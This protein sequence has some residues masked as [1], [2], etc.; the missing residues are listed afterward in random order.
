MTAASSNLPTL[1]DFAKFISANFWDRIHFAHGSKGRLR[2]SE[3]SLTE[4]LVYQFYLMARAKTLPVKIFQSNH[5]KT[6]GSDLEILLELNGLVIKLPCQ[7]K[8][9]YATRRYQALFHKVGTNQQIDL[10]IR[11]AN[12]IGGYPI[13][14]FYNYDGLVP[15]KLLKI[16]NG[17][18]Q[19]WGCSIGSAN[20]IKNKFFSGSSKTPPMFH[21]MHPGPGWPFYKLFEILNT[22]GANNVST[23]LNGFDLNVLKKYSIDEIMN[24]QAF[25]DLTS[26][27]ALGYVSHYDKVPFEIDDRSLMTDQGY[28]NPRYRVLFT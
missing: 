6:N 22:N 14:M 16:T 2:V 21:D 24:D 27:E 11:Y 9:V 17:V 5:E 19:F 25:T 15:K 26:P 10:L 23:V 18:K 20:E 13:Y 3:T 8:I 12:R 4:E 28:F 7:A 1:V